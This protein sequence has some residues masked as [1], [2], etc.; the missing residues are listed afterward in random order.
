MT[1]LCCEASI[2]FLSFKHKNYQH[3]LLNENPEN[4]E[5]FKVPY[6]AHKW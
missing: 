2:E 1:I 5:K 3:V 6:L 4:V